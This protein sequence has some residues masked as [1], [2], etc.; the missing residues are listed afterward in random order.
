M[1]SIK[2]QAV[3][4]TSAKAIT[5]SRMSMWCEYM[6]TPGS[7]TYGNGKESAHKAGY[8]GNSN[9]LAQTAHK[10]VRNAKCIARKAAIWAETAEKLGLS[11]EGQHEKLQ[12]ALA[13]AIATANAS[14]M[15]GA[16]REQNEMLGYHRDKAPNTEKM[17]ELR[18]R[19]ET[20]ELIWR[21]ECTIKRCKV[22][23]SKGDQLK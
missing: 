17:A 5:S 22:I 2:C 15:T 7:D 9:T 19:M 10:L 3:V 14:A 13:M 1:P 11:R 16:I 8:K 6:Y 4:D 18:D 20:E 23:S 12:M 21:Q